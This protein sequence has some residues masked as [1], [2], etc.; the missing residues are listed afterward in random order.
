MGVNKVENLHQDHN[1][2]YFNM[3]LDQ[4]NEFISK[5]TKTKID[6]SSLRIVPLSCN[7]KS[8]L[9]R[10]KSVAR[11][12]YR[13][14][15]KV[16]ANGKENFI[17]ILS[18]NVV[19][20]NV[21]TRNI[22]EVI[23]LM[24]RINEISK[25]HSENDYLKMEKELSDLILTKIDNPNSKAGAFTEILSKFSIIT[26]EICKKNKLNK[27]INVVSNRLDRLFRKIKNIFKYNKPKEQ[28]YDLLFKTGHIHKSLSLIEGKLKKDPSNVEAKKYLYDLGFLPGEWTSIKN[29]KADIDDPYYNSSIKFN[30]FELFSLETLRRIEKKNSEDITLEE[31]R[32]MDKFFIY[33]SG[34]L[35][36]NKRISN[37][38]KT[39][40]SDFKK[41]KFNSN[42]ILF[43]REFS[44]KTSRLSA[45]FTIAPKL[46]VVGNFVKEKKEGAVENKLELLDLRLAES[47]GNMD[48]A[49][50]WIEG[51]GLARDNN[52]LDRI[53]KSVDQV[54]LGVNEINTRYDE[55]SLSETGD[56]ILDTMEK[57]TRYEGKKFDPLNEVDWML[58]FQKNVF[59]HKN[60][61][62]AI[63]V[64]ENSR[65]RMNEIDQEYGN[66]EVSF[67]RLC[68]SDIYRIDF[69]KIIGRQGYSQ[70]RRFFKKIGKNDRDLEDHITK[71]IEEMF[72]KN[73]SKFFSDAEKFGG[74]TND[75]RR[76]I[77]SVLKPH[78]KDKKLT[79]KDLD[80]TKKQKMMC[81]EF[82]GQALF[83]VIGKTESQMK[84]ELKNKYL[85]RNVNA[86]KDRVGK[87]FDGMHLINNPISGFENFSAMHVDRLF[88]FLSGYISKV[89][90]PQF[91]N[92]ILEMP[93]N[94]H[95]AT[96]TKII[97]KTELTR[98]VAN[99]I[100]NDKLP[101]QGTEII[102]AALVDIN[103][104][105][106]QKKNRVI[107]SV[108]AIKNI[109][110]HLPEIIQ[111]IK[112]ND[113]P[114]MYFRQK[115]HMV[116][117]PSLNAS[118]ATILI[119]EEFI[120]NFETQYSK[121]KK[122]NNLV[123]F[124]QKAFNHTDACFE[125]RARTL[126]EYAQK[127]PIN[128]DFPATD[129]YDKNYSE[130]SS[131]NSILI[132][133]LQVF[134][135]K[136][137]KEEKIHEVDGVI[138]VDMFRNYLLNECRIFEINGTASDGEIRPMNEHELDSKLLYLRDDLMILE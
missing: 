40:P 3:S 49:L 42:T 118:N 138:T 46:Q 60:V 135:E 21:K 89:P 71:H 116:Y 8:N 55:E 117:H 51:L 109:K 13:I 20:T 4:F 72:K 33:I 15:L 7:V 29:Q 90:Q 64:R 66:P 129:I 81:S 84:K 98:A 25:K 67:S 47:F 122:E 37:L 31:K 65:L 54:N 1:D 108:S 130:N 41:W 110:S 96:K 11:K 104:S 105:D 63:G 88:D 113:N 30:K 123:D 58:K 17:A 85:K 36:F 97:K 44:F 107:K 9:L 87:I 102:D 77:F 127:H 28:N 56:I 38:L 48:Q 93:K 112:D 62:A 34:N 26:P 114:L 128:L 83:Y 35:D 137:I 73:I 19:K 124:F 10:T 18:N 74:I 95:E 32:Q 61:H 12:Y 132:S 45:L 43:L 121:A 133:E 79:Y 91:L 120:F 5:N 59:R 82:I 80:F 115:T 24:F 134:R 111:R 119:L 100:F 53:K 94:T 136:L 126:E 69:K 22:F 27:V 6:F 2:Y 52:L 76:Q 99:K 106:L 131:F 39:Q 78:L 103:A 16:I 57:S 92:D 101:L 75:Q 70:Y 86:D 14:E 23:P 125:A 50:N 68:I